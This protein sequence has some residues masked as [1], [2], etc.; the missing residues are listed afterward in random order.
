M[1]KI[2]ESLLLLSFPYVFLKNKIEVAT[3]WL[4]IELKLQIAIVKEER[5]INEKKPLTG[6]YST[7][8]VNFDEIDGANDSASLI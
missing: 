7:K 1:K 5:N 8:V 3:L 6:S 2:K 4:I